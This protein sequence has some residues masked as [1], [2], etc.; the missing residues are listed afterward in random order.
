MSQLTANQA[1]STVHGAI[2]LLN[3]WERLGGHLTYGSG[4]DI[5][6]ILQAPAGPARPKH[7]WPIALYA[8]GAVEVGFQYLVSRPPFDEPELRDELRNRLGEARGVDLPVDKLGKRP[9]FPVDVL[10]DLT[11]RERIVEALEW[12]MSELDRYDVEMAA[13]EAAA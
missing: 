11:A 7:I 13:R 3:A 10:A 5:S 2:E 6:C 4:D 9:S 8:S 1:P 12:F